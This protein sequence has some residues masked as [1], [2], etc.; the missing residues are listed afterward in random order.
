MVIE[1]I[2][3]DKCYLYVIVIYNYNEN[4]MQRLRVGSLFNQFIFISFH[5]LISIHVVL[6]NRLIID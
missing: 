6:V 5:S 1:Y 2:F 3:N 4:S